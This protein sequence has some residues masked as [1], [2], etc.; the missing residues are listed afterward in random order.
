EERVVQHFDR[1]RRI[2]RVFEAAAEGSARRQTQGGPKPF[3]RA[4]QPLR[5]ETIQMPAGFLGRESLVQ[6]LASE[7][8]IVRQALEEG[9]VLVDRCATENTG[10][11]HHDYFCTIRSCLLRR[12]STAAEG[13]DARLAAVDDEVAS[14]AHGAAAPPAP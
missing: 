4:F 8:A 6:R 11:F 1:R 10:W 3:P 7:V 12:G 14:A 13:H 5:N 2:E 9:D